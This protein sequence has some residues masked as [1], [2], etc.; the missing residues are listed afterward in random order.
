MVVD[1]IIDGLLVVGMSSFLS[2]LN[3]MVVVS[4]M[5]L[6]GFIVYLLSL[7]VYSV[8]IVVLLLLLLV[9]PILVGVL[10]M[11]LMDIH[12]NIIY[13]DIGFGGDPVLYQHYFWFFG[14]P[15]VYILII[16]SLE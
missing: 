15:E 7:F 4:N 5:R 13:Y 3:F 10:G 1:M 11:L 16:P 9:L 8:F 6:L 2:S 14:H 12:F